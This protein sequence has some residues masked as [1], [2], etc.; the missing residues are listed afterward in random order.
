MIIL[1]VNRDLGINGMMDYNNK[2]FTCK[3][4]P[5]DKDITRETLF[6]SR[7]TGEIVQVKYFGGNV[8]YGEIIGLINKQG[9]LQGS[10]SHSNSSSQSTAGVCTMMPKIMKDTRIVLHVKWSGADGRNIETEWIMEED[11]KETP[12]L[13]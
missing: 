12:P 13:F 7:Q 6:I 11:R 9:N 1:S 3:T 10:F 5:D 2:V 8:K 4:G